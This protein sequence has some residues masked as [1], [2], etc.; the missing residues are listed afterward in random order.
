MVVAT[1]PTV[2][3]TVGGTAMGVHVLGYVLVSKLS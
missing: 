2:M 1:P 3:V